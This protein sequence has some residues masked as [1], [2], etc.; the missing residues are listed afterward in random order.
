MIIS[1]KENYLLT[2]FIQI[3]LWI[4]HGKMEVFVVKK[5]IPQSA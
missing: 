4:K 5:I 3:V 1:L 2:I